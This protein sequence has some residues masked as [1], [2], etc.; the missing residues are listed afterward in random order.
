MNSKQALVPK[1]RFGE[2]EDEWSIGD[3]SSAQIKIIDGDRG[4]NYPNGDDFSDSGYCLFLSAKNVTKSGFKFEE[5]SFIS[6]EKDESFQRVR[7]ILW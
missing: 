1:L 3:L 6:K 7:P 5:T 2:F 4:V